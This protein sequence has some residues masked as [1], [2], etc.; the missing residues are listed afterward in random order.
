MSDKLKIGDNVNVYFD[1]LAPIFNAEVLKAPVATGD[2]WI[3]KQQGMGRE[4]LLYVQN[5]AYME[6]V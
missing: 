6:K 1:K 3:L 4:R 5:F 2:C